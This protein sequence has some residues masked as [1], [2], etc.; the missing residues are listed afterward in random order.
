[1]VDV[2][3]GHCFFFFFFGSSVVP[4]DKL[5]YSGTLQDDERSNLVFNTD[6]IMNFNGLV[7]HEAGKEDSL[8]KGGGCWCCVAPVNGD[9]NHRGKLSTEFKTMRGEIHE[10]QQIKFDE[11]GTYE[12]RGRKKTSL[13]PWESRTNG[14]S[15]TERHGCK[16]FTAR[17]S[18]S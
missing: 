15:M 5:N 12:K 16:P 13:H 17:S 18:Q 4:A 14:L 6:G 2:K 7:S 9:A 3:M 1:M 10:T 8:Q 11:K